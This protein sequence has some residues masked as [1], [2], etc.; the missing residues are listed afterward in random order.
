MVA[1]YPIEKRQLA[2]LPPHCLGSRDAEELRPNGKWLSLWL[3]QI[4]AIESSGLD[5]R[6]HRRAVLAWARLS[7]QKDFAM[8]F[9]D[10]A[11]SELESTLATLHRLALMDDQPWYLT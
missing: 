3:P 10:A 11:N 4:V 7:H 8:D 1:S 6:Y 9:V 2:G 5:W